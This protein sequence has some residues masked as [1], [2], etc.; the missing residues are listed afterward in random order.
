[1]D[2]SRVRDGRGGVSVADARGAVDVGVGER[3]ARVMT[4]KSVGKVRHDTHRLRW[5]VDDDDGR[6]RWTVDGGRE[7]RDE[8]RDAR[9]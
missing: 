2:R 6:R 1:M 9:V 3:E 4:T 7:R 5:T 8:A